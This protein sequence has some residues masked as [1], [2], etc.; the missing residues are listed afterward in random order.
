MFVIDAKIENYAENH[1]QTPY[2]LLEELKEETCQKMN[3]PQMLSG[4]IL[5][6][7]LHFTIAMMR[8]KHIL[9]VGTFT[10]Y[11]TLSM[12]SA[13]T[14]G[15]ITTIETRQEAVEMA[16]KYFKKS[17]WK[18]KITLIEG[19]A[20][21]VI[22]QLKTKFDFIYLDADKK[23]YELYYEMC[24]DKLKVHGF[25]LIDNMLWY[26]KVLEPLD[27]IS[28]ILDRL[29]KKI[30]KDFRVNNVLLTIRDGL[31]LV[32]KIQE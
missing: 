6:K 24:L 15:D 18:D 14:E 22:P 26:Q 10:G 8:P 32:Q 28:Q 3:Y 7:Y 17:P 19:N 13:L 9:E 23:N 20:L 2:F 25:L 4:K 29:N 11:G 1:T 31:Q 30:V 16:R 5:G 21:E 12:A 27:S